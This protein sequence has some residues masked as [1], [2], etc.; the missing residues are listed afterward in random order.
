MPKVVKYGRCEHEN[1]D[2]GL[3]T[4]RKGDI[5]LNAASRAYTLRKY[6]RRDT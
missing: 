3:E 2:I 5:C 1:M 4:L 6:T